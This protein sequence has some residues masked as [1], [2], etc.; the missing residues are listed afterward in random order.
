[1]NRHTNP[2]QCLQILNHLEHA[3]LTQLEALRKYGCMRLPSR[4]DELRKAGHPITTQMITHNRKRIAR[5][6]LN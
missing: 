3:P 6:S 5:Y 2:S 4:I 1:M